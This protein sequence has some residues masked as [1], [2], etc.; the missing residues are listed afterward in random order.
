[1]GYH[2]IYKFGLNYIDVHIAERKKYYCFEKINQN[3]L[4]QKR[5]EIIYNYW[6]WRNKISRFSV[7]FFVNEAFRDHSKPASPPPPPLHLTSAAV[8]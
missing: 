3:S 4:S 8:G 7:Q 2:K 5:L 1:L 6:H